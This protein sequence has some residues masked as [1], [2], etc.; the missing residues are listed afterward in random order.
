[1]VLALAGDSTM[2]SA[3]RPEP[4]ESCAP[5]APALPLPFVGGTLIPYVSHCAVCTALSPPAPRLLVAI[6]PVPRQPTVTD[7][8]ADRFPIPV[9]GGW[10]PACFPLAQRTAPAFRGRHG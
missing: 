6:G 4:S 2:T 3:L 7:G 8:L 5:L 1:M 10:S 9:P